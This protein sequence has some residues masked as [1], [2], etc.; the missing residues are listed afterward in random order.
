MNYSHV[1]NLPAQPKI[2]SWGCTWCAGGALSNFP[3]KLRPKKFSL[4][5]GCRCTHC[6]PGYPMV[7][8]IRIRNNFVYV[9]CFTVQSTLK[10]MF[11]FCNW[12]TIHVH[13]I[14]F[15]IIASRSRLHSLALV[16]G[17]S[18]KN[19]TIHFSANTSSTVLN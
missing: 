6:T 1:Q 2:D 7:I 3:Y 4:P 15:N 17:L 18:D 11:L 13:L 16:L 14:V 5:W 12:N 9:L 10:S 8:I 19:K